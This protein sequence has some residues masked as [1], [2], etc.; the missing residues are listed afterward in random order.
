MVQL[1]E[2]VSMSTQELILNV[3]ITHCLCGVCV[4][5]WVHTALMAG[6]HLK[7]HRLPE[8]SYWPHCSFATVKTVAVTA[9][10]PLLLLKQ[11]REQIIAREVLCK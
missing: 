5:W 2:D 11:P 1:G 3:P 8:W 10:D 6:W 7:G 4:E 9:R